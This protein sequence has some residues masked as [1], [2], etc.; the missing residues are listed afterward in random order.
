MQTARARHRDSGGPE[1]AG[2]AAANWPVGAA[3]SRTV[4]SESAE[5]DIRR[6]DSESA[7]SESVLQV[8]LSPN[9]HLR[10]RVRDHDCVPAQAASVQGHS[11][12]GTD[13][14]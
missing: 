14:D 11:V 9:L 10:D 13:R 7:G 5:S 8:P 6:G 4:D 1:Q 12:T 2:L 3:G